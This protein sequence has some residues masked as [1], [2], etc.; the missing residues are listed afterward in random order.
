MSEK[1]GAVWKKRDGQRADT[2]LS[3]TLPHGAAPSRLSLLTALMAE[4]KENVNSPE[5]SLKEEGSDQ[6]SKVFFNAKGLINL[7]LSGTVGEG[8]PEAL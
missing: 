5:M 4:N 8:A 3:R 7:G 2:S 6:V 1:T